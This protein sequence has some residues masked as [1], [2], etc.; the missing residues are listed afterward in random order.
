M[1]IVVNTTVNAEPL[2]PQIFENFA[3]HLKTFFLSS[4]LDSLL[5]RFFLLCWICVDIRVPIAPSLG[6]DWFHL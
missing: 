4:Y 3:P 6:P 5:L 2:S 1:T